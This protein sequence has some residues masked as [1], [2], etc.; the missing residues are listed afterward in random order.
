MGRDP[1]RR[2]HGYGEAA[3]IERYDESARVGARLRRGARRRA[4]RRP[5]RARGDHGAAAGARVRGARGDRRRAARS[6]GQARR[7]AGV[8]AARAARVGP[9]T[10]WT[11]WLGDPDDMARRAE[12]GRRPLQAAQAEARRRA[13]GSTSSAC[14]PCA[15]VADVPLQV[16]VNEAWTLDEALDALPQLAELGV[17]YCEQPLSAGRSRRAELKARSPIPIYVDEDCHTLADVAAC[18]E[19]AHGINVKLAKSGGIRE[20]VRMVHAA[21][22][23][24]LGCMLGCMVESGLGI[25]AGAHIASL[26]DHVDLD[27]NIL[28]ARGPV[29]GRGASSTA[30]RCPPSCRVSA[31]RA[32]DPLPDPR[33]G[34]LRRPALRQDDVRR[35]PLPPRRRRRDPR[36]DARA[37]RTEDGVPVVAERGEALRFE[38]NT[39]L[40]GVATQGGRFPPAW[41][42]L[43]RG[44]VEPGLDVENGLHDFLPTSRA[45]RD[46]RGTRRRAARPAPAA[47]R[48]ST[49]TGENLEVAGDDRPRGRLR[50]RDR[51]DDRGAR[52]RPRGAAAGHALGVRPNGADGDRDRRLGHLGRRGRRRLHRRRR[53]AASR[54]GLRRG[55]EQRRCSGS[56]GRARSSIRSTPASRSASTTA[57]FRTCSCSATKPGA[58]RSRAP[59]AGRIRS[60]RCASSSSCTSGSPCRR[61]RRASPPSP[62]TRG[63]RRG[64]RPGGDRR[65]RGRDRASGG[66]PR[67]LR[68]RPSLSTRFSRPNSEG[69]CHRPPRSA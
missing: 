21:R 6:P 5:V 64:R 15:S 58:P 53:R 45:A 19:R 22:A 67:P 57:A 44:C 38:P 46:R 63:A 14:A 27:G 41:R 35:A 68:R 20:A 4:R 47:R 28:L 16:D 10:S 60:L 3:P 56:K 31:S 11:I 36:L 39:A 30:S 51:E 25:A 59:A 2:R 69:G 55:G 29:A 43:L 66:R 18:A 32:R 62:S 9:P 34:L 8:P 33:G 17:E 42:D 49:A 24:G 26:F 37:R 52:A 65:R 13:T 12:S 50:L 1:A 23:L 61:G 48:T 7:A 54:R 40:V